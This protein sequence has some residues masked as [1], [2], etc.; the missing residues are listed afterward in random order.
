MTFFVITI[1]I[2]K[3]TSIVVSNDTCKDRRVNGG[4]PLNF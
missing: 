1:C 2:I 4:V 3:Q